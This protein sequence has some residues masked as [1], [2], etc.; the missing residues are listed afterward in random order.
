MLINGRIV[1]CVSP[2]TSNEDV[3]IQPPGESND[4]MQKSTLASIYNSEKLVKAR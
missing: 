2:S 3:E 1:T 4:C